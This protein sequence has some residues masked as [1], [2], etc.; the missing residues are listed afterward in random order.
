MLD[1][2][3]S[4]FSSF[5]TTFTDKG[6]SGFSPAYG[7]LFPLFQSI[8]EET[9]PALGYI[10]EELSASTSL[11][12]NRASTSTP[13]VS[14]I[15]SLA[16]SYQPTTIASPSTDEVIILPTT[17]I[18]TPSIPAEMRSIF[19]S[20]SPT[21]SPIDAPAACPQGK[22]RR[23]S[24]APTAAPTTS[25]ELPTTLPLSTKHLHQRKR[26][27]LGSNSPTYSP[28]NYPS[29]TTTSLPIE[30]P[31]AQT[32]PKRSNDARKSSRD[33][34]VHTTTQRTRSTSTHKSPTYAP[35][36]MHGEL[37]NLRKSPTAAPQGSRVSSY[38]LEIPVI[39]AIA[40]TLASKSPSY[41]PSHL[42]VM[43]VSQSDEE[44]YQLINS[45]N[46]S[47]ASTEQNMTERSSTIISPALTP[48]QIQFLVSHKQ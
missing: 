33:A 27:S 41:T 40:P 47:W 7:T 36:N 5:A 17:Y 3:E 35:S 21:W 28:E 39:A 43:K 31:V 37:P 26:Q 4:S 24:E 18:A 30:Y 34:E 23:S 32:R 9:S 8:Q 15:P 45:K 19:T 44:R 38:S 2:I 42:P 10:S 22:R 46:N 1:S 12:E 25:S 13:A 29:L 16:P 14:K 48:V 20:K 11:S 6:T